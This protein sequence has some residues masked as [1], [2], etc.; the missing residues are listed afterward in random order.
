MDLRRNGEDRIEARDIAKNVASTAVDVRLTPCQVW[1]GFEDGKLC[2]RKPNG[3]PRACGRFVF[4]ACSNVSQH[5]HHSVLLA[6]ASLKL[7]EECFTAF[8]AL[9]SQYPPPFVRC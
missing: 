5:L 4:N 1:E 3:E 6:R 2:L 8:N 9:F 7:N